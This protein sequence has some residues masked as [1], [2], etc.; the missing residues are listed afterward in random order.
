MYPTPQGIL[1]LALLAI[2]FGMQPLLY[3]EFAPKTLN[4]KSIV[5]A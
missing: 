1:F 2:Q 4:K 5:L 3:R